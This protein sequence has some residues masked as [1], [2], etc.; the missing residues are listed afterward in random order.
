MGVSRQPAGYWRVATRVTDDDEGGPAVVPGP[1]GADPSVGLDDGSV[2]VRRRR[3]LLGVVGI[4]VVLAVAGLL[5]STA[6][7]SPADE[8]ADAAPPEPTL[9][10]A[11]VVRTTVRETVI[12]RGTVSA[13]RQYEVTPAAPQGGAQI[14]TAEGLAAGSEIAQGALL[15]EVAG[16]PLFALAGEKPAYRDLNPGDRGAD[17]AQLQG[18]L[19]SL[20]FDVSGDDLGVYGSATRDAVGA[21]Y[22]LS[23]YEPALA[24][25]P[26]ALGAARRAVDDARG[27]LRELGAAGAGPA[28]I[29]AARQVLDDAT[30]NLAVV[31][32]T[33]GPKVPLAEHIFLP[34]FP[35]V[36]VTSNARVGATVDAPLLVVAAGE[37]VVVGELNRADVAL[38]RAGM[39]AT[40]KGS[41]VDTTGSV[42]SVGQRSPD[43]VEGGATTDSTGSQAAAGAASPEVVITPSAPLAPSTIG[44]D[45]QVTI[46]SAA[47]AGDVLAVP[48]AAISV[49]ADG[50]TYLS[51]VD[52]DERRAVQVRTGLA[53]AGLVEV[54]PVDGELAV[55][56][57]VVTSG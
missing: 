34:T 52:G 24:G 33:T 54:A 43:S 1:A 18:S 30:E 22:R 17:V 32:S 14:V 9:L 13:A 45:L 8:L 48:V 46:E 2:G 55:G 53:G 40:L 37:L 31:D 23:G 3:A 44:A 15:V 35:G 16:R 5:A 47:S 50:Q 38:V 42:A 25:D 41:G 20:G 26:G 6:I 19:T 21:F 28:E 27:R 4:A 51:V 10:T 49:R 11:D 29:G 36:V 56:D 39:P 7:R 12:V 57:Q